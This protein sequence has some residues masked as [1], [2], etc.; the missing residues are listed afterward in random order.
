MKNVTIRAALHSSPD[1]SGKH[2]IMISVRVN[3]KRIYQKTGFKCLL[4][5]WNG[6]GVKRTV[7][8]ADRI[9][10][11]IRQKLNEIE[12]AILEIDLKKQPIT[13]LAVKRI[14]NGTDNNYDFFTFA[15]DLETD[16]EQKYSSTTLAI[17]KNEVR[18]LKTFSPS[19][20]F[21]DINHSFLRKYESWLITDQKLSNNSI[22]KAWKILKKII[23]TAI[24]E[25]K[26]FEY[27]FT[28]FDNPKYRQTDRLY[29]TQSEVDRIEEK[30]QLPMPEGMRKAGYYFLLG[31]N[32]GLRFSDWERFNYKTWV[33]G[34]RL[35]LRAKKNG[36]V[37]SM[38]IHDK[39][40][41]ILLKV[42]EIGPVDSGQ[43]TNEY[44]KGLAT[45]AD[46]DKPITCHSSRHSFAI[47]CAEL[48][49]SIEAT[50]TFM[51]ITPK[52]ANV[53]YKVTG[54][55]LDSEI[56]RWNA[57]GKNDQRK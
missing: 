6:E 34:D 36:E 55:K 53:Y 11:S 12:A 39:L 50:A 28:G 9:N 7:N 4:N 27:P 16:L 54:I 56:E 57:I 44:L 25:K 52:I 30:L 1:A 24:R 14:F 35:I 38:K 37:V 29:L 32:S 48:G 47:R 10:S 5:D 26:T 15:D 31:C 3:G 33:V 20:S 17:F 40:K 49:I 42:S 2:S 51:G 19:L 41:E 13:P 21:S 22:H 43:K 45:L 18:R 8:N 23:N 46:I